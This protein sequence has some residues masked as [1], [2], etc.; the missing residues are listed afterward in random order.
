MASGE[1][2]TDVSPTP[3][4][5]VVRLARNP[6]A[7][8]WTALGYAAVLAVL[9]LVFHR[10]GDLESESDFF[11]SYVL[12]ARSFL[13][14]S[15]AVD[16]YRGPVYPIM[17]ALI[18][19]PLRLLGA[20]YFESG[21]IL[22]VLAA[23]AVL[24]FT[25]RLLSRWLEPTTAL[26]ATLLITV[27]WVF[28]R[29][30]Y[31]TGTD[32]VFAAQ[33]AAVLFAA[34]S[35]Q[36][37]RGWRPGVLG[38]LCGI[39]YLTRYNGV[40]LF[41][42]VLASVFLFDVW[43]LSWL[44]RAR[45][46]L[47]LI[48][49]FVVVLAPWALY[50]KAQTGHY[51]LNRNYLN[52]AYGAY[53]TTEGTT[54]EFLAEHP[55]AF[56]GFHD[57][58]FYDPPRLVHEVGVH[59]IQHSLLVMRRVLSFPLSLFMIIGFVWLLFKRPPRGLVLYALTGMVFYALL[60][61]IFYS[62]RFVL[63]LVPIA[64]TFATLGFVFVSDAVSNRTRI[65]PFARWLHVALIVLGLI[66]CVAFNARVIRGSDPVFREMG[67]AFAREHPGH[68]TGT[69]VVA[70]KGHFGYFAGLK[71]VGLPLVHSHAE[72][73]EYVHRVGA[74]YLFFSYVGYN[75]RP[76][77]IYLSDPRL[78]H[79]GLVLLSLAPQSPKGGFRGVL[80]RVEKTNDKEAKDK[81]APATGDE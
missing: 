23:G 10:T 28:V 34:F 71:T 73:M 74:D 8:L 25:Q 12:Q 59:A 15:I 56:N 55:G 50:S 30:S 68:D 70:R 13:H 45:A 62:D 7:A 22:S 43:R 2:S 69:T 44:R 51:L 60:F 37:A 76:D 65:P 26:A 57:V 54:E 1:P 63:L 31:T 46:V 40:V 78:P 52:I 81:A 36:T 77:L 38:L 24:Y 17:V 9:G 53:M 3:F 33:G 58:L 5:T 27:N 32:M 80:Y 79:P 67:E 11:D 48:A 72:L 42:V 49:G 41:L 39:T 14:G 21:I 16:P 75:T 64:C 29:Y 19:L 4:T 6:R 66:A 61:L 18:S 35:P 20:G 47:L